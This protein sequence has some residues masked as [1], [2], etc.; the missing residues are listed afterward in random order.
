MSD[1]P[2]K[3]FSNGT[4]YEIFKYNYCEVCRNHKARKDGFT[5]FVEDGGCPIENAMEDARF[6][7]SKFPNKMI[8]EIRNDSKVLKYHHCLKFEANGQL[9]E[10]EQKK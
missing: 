6:D 2:S 1:Y 7:I 4:E 5:A 8:R 9:K 3:P 10:G